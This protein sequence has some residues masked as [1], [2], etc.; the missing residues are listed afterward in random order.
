MQTRRNA[1]P[2]LVAV[3]VLVSGAGPALGAA[4]HD[5]GHGNDD[6]AF[7]EPAS[8]AEADRSVRVRAYD[9]MTF[10]P[11]P[12]TVEAGETVR[13]VVTNAGDA[14]HSF[15]LGTPAYQHRHEE[16]MAGMPTGE[17][18][19]HMD[20][21]PNGVVVSPGETGTLT[22]TFEQG[23]PVQ[24]ACHIPGHYRA[25]MKGAVRLQ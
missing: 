23:G 2:I 20:D 11:S 21:T 3:T 25:G 12:V 19:D 6:F 17:L 22:W 1:L 4:G 14:Q 7:G 24:F 15:T 13:F 18:A 5:G 16:A 10:D 8:A 9:S